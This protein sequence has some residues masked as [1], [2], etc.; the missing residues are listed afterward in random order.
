MYMDVP[1]I[2]LFVS[3]ISVFFIVSLLLGCLCWYLW[4]GYRNIPDVPTRSKHII[5][6]LNET[7]QLEIEESNKDK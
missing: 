1:S 7:T 6:N 3:F 4:G 2:L 5:E